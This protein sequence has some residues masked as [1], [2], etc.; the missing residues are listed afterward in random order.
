[1]RILASSRFLGTEI[2]K[3]KPNRN[4][5]EFISYID[6]NLQVHTRFELINI[7]VELIELGNIEQ[8]ELMRQDDRRW[9][10]LVETLLAVSEQPVTLEIKPNIINV[11]FQY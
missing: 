10:W 6:P 4:Q 9:D 8:G 3:L 2:K 11:I 7:P 1:M 5:I